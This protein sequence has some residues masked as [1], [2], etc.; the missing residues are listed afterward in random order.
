MMPFGLSDQGSIAGA[1]ALLSKRKGP[2]DGFEVS[3]LARS[4]LARLCHPQNHVAISLARD[5]HLPEPVDELRV[6]P[7]PDQ[8]VGTWAWRRVRRSEEHCLNGLVR[9]RGN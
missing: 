6:Q 7:D 5:A 1:H 8:A 9:G 4:S 2:L 3:A